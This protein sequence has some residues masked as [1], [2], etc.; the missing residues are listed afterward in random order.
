MKFISTITHHLQTPGA[1]VEQYARSKRIALAHEIRGAQKIYL[2]TKFWILLR[3]ARLGRPDS[4]DVGKLLQ[5]LETLVLR[6]KVLC[7][8]SVDTFAEIF[9]Q[10]DPSTLR[11]TVQLIDDLSMG[12]SILE[13]GERVDLE[14]SHFI[15]EKTKGSGAVYALDDLV[16]TKTAY[17][18]GFVTPIPHG[19]PN[20]K[21]MAIQKAFV[22]QMWIITL[23]DMLDHMGT[24]APQDSKAWFSEDTTEKLNQGKLSHMHEYS[25]FKQ[26]FLN[27]L[28]GLLD[29]HKPMLA[30]LMRHIYES[31]T[32]KIATWDE[33]EM[34][35]SGR[36]VVNL[37]YHAFRLNKIKSEMPSFRAYAGL[38]AAMRWDAKRKSL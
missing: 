34:A 33:V 36:L 22:D 2:D 13:L 38:H 29:V 18:L 9:K 16:W 8:L 4:N 15:R 31:D 21:S 30:D 28:A 19:L 23:T 37:I 27:E 7:P 32:G 25:S 3:D 10:S 17:V 5:I 1:T 14:V 11:A 6:R 26:L 20:K 12:I 35:D 24:I